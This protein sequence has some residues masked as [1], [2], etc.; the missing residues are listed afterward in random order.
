M[1]IRVLDNRDAGTNSRI[2]AGIRYAADNGADIIN[3]SIGGPQNASV[4]SALEYA[5]A[6]D[7]LVVAAA[8]NDDD[9]SPAYPAA[10]SATLPNLLSVG[11][12]RA[13][14]SL[15]GFSNDVGVSGAVQIDAPGINILSTSIGQRTLFQSGT[16][17]AAPHV[18]GLAALTLSANPNLT[19]SELRNLIVAGA[20]MT[21][22]GSDSHGAVNAARTVAA[23]A[24][25]IA[26][27]EAAPDQFTQTTSATS[28]PISVAATTA[29]AIA[30]KHPIELATKRVATPAV[31]PPDAVAKATQ[32]EELRISDFAW[33]VEVWREA[34][35][36]D[37]EIDAWLD[38]AFPNR[39]AAASRLSHPSRVG[40]SVWR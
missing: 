21:I 29:S 24:R 1:P 6:R 31:P 5:L 15:G 9:A 17:L 28:P 8:G 23:A 20:E 38:E 19:A 33:L 14:G 34:R 4:F 36:G 35:R 40:R 37:T 22:S 25:R 7:V 32:T 10:F 27:A 12:Y 39:A 16:S 30:S 11:A 26:T 2:A 13:A 3:L 18:A